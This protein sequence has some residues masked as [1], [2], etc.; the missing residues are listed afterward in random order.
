MTVEKFV[1][2]S[3]MGFLFARDNRSEAIKVLVRHL[4]ID[5]SMATNIYDS[6]RPIMTGDGAL[7]EETQKKMIAFFSKIA[8]AKD[9]SSADKVFDFS[10][11]RKAQATL[12]A[13][14]WKAAL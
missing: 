12:Q 4:R 13:R 5:E 6:S 14:G 10:I 8:G 7:S 3:L 1:R 2:A 9:L 11:L